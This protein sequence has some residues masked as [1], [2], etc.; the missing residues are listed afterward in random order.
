MKSRGGK[1][2]LSI[3]SLPKFNNIIW[4]LPEDKLTV[5][6]ART[7]QGKTAFAMQL[8]CDLLE[9][10]KTVMY[11]GFEMKQDEFMERMFSHIEKI[12]NFELL[13]G[14]VN[15][16]D[17][18]F[19]RFREYISRVSF[20]ATD[21]FGKSWKDINKFLDQLSNSP[22]VIVIDYIQAISQ[23]AGEGKTF[24]DDYILNLRN[25]CISRGFAGILISQLNRNSQDRKD[26]TPQL[27]DLKGSGFL[28]E[29][30]DLVILLEWTGKPTNTPDYIINVA[31]NRRG[32]TGFL[33][34]NYE[35]KYHIFTDSET[36]IK[37][38]PK[39][40]DQINWQDK[41]E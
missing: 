2:A 6:G 15:N 17:E 13:T 11:M 34:V 30:V 9:Q 35:P 37:G 41:G 12:D 27:H 33:K 3:T 40:K 25:M 1:P 29:L 20:L 39:A 32:R 18:K 14:K 8:I 21:N 28:E 36:D 7:S 5:I 16:F 24:I 38:D 22:D 23:G 31:K 26:K 10:G 4:G 19:K